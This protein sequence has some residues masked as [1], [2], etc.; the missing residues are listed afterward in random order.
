MIQLA[1]RQHG[2]TGILAA[3]GRTAGSFG[4]AVI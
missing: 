4:G 3:I 1:V 2:N